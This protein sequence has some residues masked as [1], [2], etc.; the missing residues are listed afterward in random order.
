M[1]KKLLFS[2]FLAFLIPSIALASDELQ[3]PNN[4]KVYIQGNRISRIPTPG[5]QE[6]NLPINNDYQANPACYMDCYSR[7]KDT[8]VYKI[9]EST[10]INGMVRV[11]G[12]Y[13]EREC[14]PGTEDE[15]INLCKKI[16]TCVNEECWLSADTGA[17]YGIKE[18]PKNPNTVTHYDIPPTVP[19][20]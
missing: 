9:D 11:A 15:L 1:F 12:I 18:K 16:A 3:L 5:Y 6:R 20:N 2:S 13:H 17:L 19:A 8:G 14:M 7:N 10:Y 4:L